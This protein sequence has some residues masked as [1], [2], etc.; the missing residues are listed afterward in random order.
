MAL[1]TIEAGCGYWQ[2]ESRSTADVMAEVESDLYATEACELAEDRNGRADA[3]ADGATRTRTREVQPLCAA[4]YT[5]A[6]A[7]LPGLPC[8]VLGVRPSSKLLRLVS[9]L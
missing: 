5:P 8:S 3:S 7:L 6:D 4:F 1:A 2:Q 9:G